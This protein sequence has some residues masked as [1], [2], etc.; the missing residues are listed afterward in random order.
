MSSL[1]PPKEQSE[2][3][4]KTA[5]TLNTVATIGAGH[6]IVASTPAAWRAKIPGRKKLVQSGWLNEPAVHVKKPLPPKIDRILPKAG[7]S[8]KIA[9][10][11]GA[12]GWLT[13]HGGELAGDIMA[14]RSINNQIKQKQKSSSKVDSVKK[15]DQSMISKAEGFVSSNGHGKSLVEKKGTIAALSEYSEKNRNNRDEFLASRGGGRYNTIGSG[16][17]G[18]LAGGLVGAEIGRK[19]SWKVT[20]SSPNYD[21]LKLVSKPSNKNVAIGAGIGAASLAGLAGI[22]NAAARHR[23]AK[24]TGVEKSLAEIAK[25]ANTATALGA[26]PTI[27]GIAAPVYNATQARKGRK[28]AVAGRTFGSMAAYGAGAAALGTGALYANAARQ[29]TKPIVNT[30]AKTGMSRA[31]ATFGRK[32]A[33]ALGLGVLGSSGYGARR[34]YQNAVK[35]GDIT[36]AYRRFDPEADRQRRAGL[37]TGLGA[38]GAGLAG[39]EAANHF[40]TRSK[41]GEKTARGI[42]AK[43]GHGKKGLALAALAGASGALGAHSYKGAL[44]SRNQPWT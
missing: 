14:R 38:L 30:T 34:A 1:K 20:H 29:G 35:R 26:T 32:P 37:Y 44:S 16:V 41:V 18:G 33:L 11:A 15:N 5:R 19:K 3:E 9:A 17:V 31:A 4:L 22:E 2:R 23:H 12:A 24:R 7:T 43:P 28:A 25:G 40:T 21:A 27:G 36:K 39:R 42:V 13:L 10:G 6:A 8:A